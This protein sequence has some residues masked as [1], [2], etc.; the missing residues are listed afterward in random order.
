MTLPIPTELPTS[1]GSRPLDVPL[2][3]LT[4]DATEALFVAHARTVYRYAR[5]RLPAADAEDVVAEVFAIA[6]RKGGQV[7]A[8]PRAW[9]LGVARRVLANQVRGQRRRAALAERL[10]THPAAAGPDDTRL[11][12]E[13]DE[14]RRAIDR[15]RP[16]D[17]EV[18]ALLAAAELTTGELA[19][20]LGCSPASAATRAHRARRRLRAAYDRPTED[21]A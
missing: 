7:P 11:V 1:P 3:P 10:S 14:L 18:I 2:D 5:T 17:R 9:L 19:E 12:R 8:D 6:W 13:L 21:G 20:V 15:L 16:A 4:P